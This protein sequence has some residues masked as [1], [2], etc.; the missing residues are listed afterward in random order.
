MAAAKPSLDLLRAM[1]DELA[2]R[3]LADAPRLI[4]SEI[5]ERTGLSKPTVAESVR[6]LEAIGLVIDTG[7]RTTGR[8][9]VGS[10]YAL[11]PDAGCALVV[12]I[13]PGAVVAETVDSHGEVHS[14]V[15]MDVTRHSAPTV[16]TRILKQTARAALRD[17]QAPIR[18]AV[19]SAAGPVDRHSQRLIQLPDAPFLSGALSPAKVLQPLMDGPVLVDNDVHW[20]ARAE[21][22]ADPSTMDDFAYLYLGEGLGCAIISDGEVVRGHTGVAGEVA[23]ITTAGLDGRAV[24]FTE[25]FAELGLRHPGSTAIDVERLLVAAQQAPEVLT[26]LANAVSGVL[27][28]IVALSDPSCIVLGGP[29][30]ASSELVAAVRSNFAQHPRT[31]TIRAAAIPQEPSLV[32]ARG[33]AVAALRAELVAIAALQQ[34]QAGQG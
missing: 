12:Q 31:V 1:T 20:A 8:G 9:G 29:W 19:V 33:Q 11:A 23:H 7:E 27:A 5:A 26:A 17:V 28:A 4:R 6:R 32:G 13:A 10:Y 24:S 14:R 2:L 21:R 16:A 15:E 18:V 25:V 34:P 22:A 30:G 3:A